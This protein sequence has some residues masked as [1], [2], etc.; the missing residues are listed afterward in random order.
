MLSGDKTLE[1]YLNKLNL[2]T[3]DLF[4]IFEVLAKKR[5]WGDINGA[6]LTQL[7]E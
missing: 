5:D 7:L 3:E 2:S 6:D 4:K 1:D